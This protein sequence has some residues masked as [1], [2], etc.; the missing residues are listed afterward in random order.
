VVG[1]GRPATVTAV[2]AWLSATGL[3]LLHRLVPHSGGRTPPRTAIR[4]WIGGGAVPGLSVLLTAGSRAA[5]A[6]AREIRARFGR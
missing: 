1:A 5:R 2:S 4:R 6:L 3:W